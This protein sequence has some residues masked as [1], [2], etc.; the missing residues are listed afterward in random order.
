MA[1]QKKI[2]LRLCLIAGALPVLAVVTA[3]F[4]LAAASTPGQADLGGAGLLETP[5]ARMMPD[6]TVAA[7]A[8]VSGRDDRTVTLALQP[9]PWL[10]ATLR[11]TLR[12][13]NNGRSLP[14]EG[15]IG[16]KLGLSAESRWWPALALGLRDLAGGRFAGEYLVAAK[17]WSG[18]DF[19]LGL[20][21]GRLGESGGLGNPLRGLGGR[22]RRARQPATAPA[23]PPS[24]F[25]G[26]AVAPFG[27]LS[28]QT[29]LPGLVLALEFSADRRRLERLESPGLSPGAPVNAGLSWRPWDWL[30]LG[31]GLEHG[32]EVRARATLLTWEWQA[33]GWIKEAQQF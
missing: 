2:S 32:R 14:V 13:E 10:E 24:W 5:S 33:R 28:W 1:W 6:G 18:L 3:G 16:L 26:A 8:G 12:P 29:P 9:L 27:G 21:W 31:A 25:T 20:G 19:S 11:E 23:G 4:A 22:Y 15:G 30:E 17:R 7:G